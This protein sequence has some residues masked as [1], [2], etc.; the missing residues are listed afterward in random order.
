MNGDVDLLQM[1]VTIVCA[2]IASSGFWAFIQKYFDKHSYADK[3]L[4]GITHDRLLYLGHQYLSRG[5]WITDDE[6]E[7]I[8]DYMYVPYVEMGGNGAV[9]KMMAEI[10]S[11]LGI[12][13]EPPDS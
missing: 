9:K 11:K 4:L 7:N 13:P 1:A 12:V 10:D 2:V 5:D 6:Y 8:H 3:M